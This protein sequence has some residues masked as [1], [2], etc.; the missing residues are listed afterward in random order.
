MM[1][2]QYARTMRSLG[3]LHLALCTPF[4]VLLGEAL[5][6]AVWH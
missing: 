1:S 3:L 4:A 2:R 5:H 6:A